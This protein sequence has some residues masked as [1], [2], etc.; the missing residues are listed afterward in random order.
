MFF[1]RFESINRN[2]VDIEEHYH[3]LLTADMIW[4]WLQD[5]F[6]ITH[7]NIFTGDNGSGKNSQLLAF[8]FLGYRVFYVVS[9]SAPN[10]FTKMG[11]IEE[12]QITVAEDEADDIGNDKQKKNIFTSGY[13]SGGS[14]P[15]VELEGGRRSDDWLTYSQKWLAMEELPNNKKIKGVLDRSFVLRFVPGHVKYNIKDVI[16]SAGDPKFKPLYDELIETRKLMFCWRLI[17]YEDPILDVNLNV[18]NRSAELTKPL[19]RLFQNSRIALA[20]ILESLTKFMI[21]RNEVKQTSFESKLHDVISLLINERKERIKNSQENEED[22]ALELCTFTNHMIREKCIEIMEGEEMPDKVGIFYSEEVGSF[23]QTRIT[24]ISKSKFKAKSAPK[25]LNVIIKNYDND[26]KEEVKSKTFR[27]LQY[28]EQYLNR[29]KINYNIPEKIEIFPPDVEEAQYVTPV[30]PVTLPRG[31]LPLYTD[32]MNAKITA[33]S[34]NL[35]EN[36]NKN[37]ENHTNSVVT[38]TLKEALV[39]PRGLTSVTSVTK[40]ALYKPKYYCEI[41]KKNHHKRFGTEIKEQYD[42]HMLKHQSQAQP[43]PEPLERPCGICKVVGM[44]KPVE[45]QPGGGIKW[46]V[47]HDDGQTCV[48]EEYEDIKEMERHNAARIRKERKERKDAK[49]VD[50]SNVTCF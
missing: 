41:C 29:I 46:Q 48:W 9:A 6:G 15:K 10:Y 25:R 42:D 5:K 32:I 28:Q 8:K 20:R 49:E 17:H 39:P 47:I 2:F 12:G 44:R 27:C 16:R 13:S 35:F 37:D 26:G 30:T 14:V 11:N 50:S 33:I 18:E 38:N 45:R 19:I 21:E 4:T 3:V 34:R 1:L 36:S 7:Y 24:S 40:S 22:K 23:S 31:I 43:L